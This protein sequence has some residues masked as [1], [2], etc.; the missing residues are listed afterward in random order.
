M[1]FLNTT[2][3][4]L[5]ELSAAI[6]I[7]N[8]LLSFG[9][10]LL[11]AVIYKKTHRGLSYSRSYVESL[12][13]MSVLAA[14]AMMILGNNVVMALGILGVFTLIRF[15][16]IIKDTKDATYLFFSLAVGMGVVTANYIVSILGTGA[17]LVIIYFLDKYNFGSVTQD[18]FLLTFIADKN[19]SSRF[20]EELFDK[21]LGSYKLLQHKTNSDGDGEFYF[22]VAF[23]DKVRPEDLV[24]DLNENHSI[25][26]TDLIVGKDAIEY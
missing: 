3:L 10:S 21:Y 11:I 1:N 26:L 19:F 16:T 24:R 17:L 7:F 14:I 2:D 15:R 20:Y 12:V 18:G 8:I 5:T 9:L 25:K 22:S 13:M 6:I 4:A 23:K